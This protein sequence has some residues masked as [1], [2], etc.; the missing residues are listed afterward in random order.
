MKATYVIDVNDKDA[1]TLM[2]DWLTATG[3]IDDYELVE[4]RE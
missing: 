1:L 3:D 2:L 4:E